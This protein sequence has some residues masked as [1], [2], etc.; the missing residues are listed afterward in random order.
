MFQKMIYRM[1]PLF[2]EHMDFFFPQC[3]AGQHAKASVTSRVHMRSLTLQLCNYAYE[4]T[5]AK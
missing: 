3:T 4:A 2:I 5:R 1:T